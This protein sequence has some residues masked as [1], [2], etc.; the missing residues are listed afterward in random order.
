MRS[1]IEKE[2]SEKLKVF[3]QKEFNV[4]EGQELV[5]LANL[6]SHLALSTEIVRLQQVFNSGKQKNRL[7]LRRIRSVLHTL[8]HFGFL[9][10]E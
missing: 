5:L 4:Q 9:S 6:F 2:Q 7:S 3:L 10:R 8:E 1:V